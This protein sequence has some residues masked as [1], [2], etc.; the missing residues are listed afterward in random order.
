[1]GGYA[2]SEQVSLGSLGSQQGA[3]S[4]TAVPK[5]R[6]ITG[7]KPCGGSLRWRGSVC[8]VA[9][10]ASA[11]EAGGG[12]DVLTKTKREPCGSGGRAGRLVT[13]RLLVPSLAPVCV[14]VSLSKGTG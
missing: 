5:Q 4:T 10:A 1:M 8:S 14:E 7:L 12:E 11:T 9:A 3:G 13:R 2:E 6:G